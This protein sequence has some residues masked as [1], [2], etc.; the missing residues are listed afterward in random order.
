VL[1]SND[2]AYSLYL[3]LGFVQTSESVDDI[4]MKVSVVQLANDLGTL[5]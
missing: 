5:S 4:S 2:R 1:R 3:S